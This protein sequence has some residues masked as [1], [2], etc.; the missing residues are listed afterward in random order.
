MKYNAIC[1][2]DLI[3]SQSA[4]CAKLL[5]SERLII[6]LPMI[7]FVFGSFVHAHPQNWKGKCNFFS[8]IY[9]VRNSNINNSNIHTIV[10]NFINSA[11]SMIICKCRVSLFA[12]FSYFVKNNCHFDESRKVSIYC[13]VQTSFDNWYSWNSMTFFVLNACVRGINTNNCNDN[14]S[15]IWLSSLRNSESNDESITTDCGFYIFNSD[16]WFDASRWKL[17]SL[18]RFCCILAMAF[19]VWNCFPCHI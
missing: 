2:V 7:I 9:L 16:G 12:R 4:L 19:N 18:C 17:Y 5:I 13:N 6:F 3:D 8:H 10:I 1:V 11:E 15:N 14:N